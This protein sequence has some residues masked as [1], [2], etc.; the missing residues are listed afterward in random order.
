MFSKFRQPT[1]S[2]LSLGRSVGV[3]NVL[4]IS[5]K[6]TNNVMTSIRSMSTT[7]EQQPS[8]PS[9]N[10]QEQAKKES[11]EVVKLDFDDYDD[12]EPQTPKD[13]IAFYGSLFGRL[14]LLCAI[15]AGVVYTA[16]ELLGQSPQ[17]LFSA[18]FDHIRY[19]DVIVEMVGD[20][21]K[22]FGRDVGRNTEGRRNHVDSY[23][24]KA[25]D[26]ST[27]LRVRFNIKGDKAQ[28]RVWAESSSKLPSDQYVYIIVQSLRT[29]QVYTVVDNRDMIAAGMM[30]GSD[31]IDSAIFKALL[32]GGK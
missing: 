27:R 21:A 13:K 1:L 31:T 10:S 30:S 5:P 17:G 18:V 28:I 2:L 16:S 24:Y 12:Y 8:S 32:P 29:G 15:V 11:T 20:N 7:P 26:G 3:R 25:E 19:N 23:K 4:K 6:M 9:N 22:A 14:A